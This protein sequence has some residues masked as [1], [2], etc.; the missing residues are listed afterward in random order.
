MNRVHLFN[1]DNDLALANFTPSFTPP[2]YA[3]EMVRGGEVLPY[4]LAADGDVVIASQE[5]AGWFDLMNRLTGKSVNLYCEESHRGFIPSPWGWSPSACRRFL[6]AGVEQHHIP[7]D[8]AIDDIRQL[9]HRRTSVTINRLLRQRGVDTPA[10]PVEV[11]SMDEFIDQFSVDDKIMLKSPWSS[12]GRGVIDSTTMPWRQFMRHV[13]GIIGRQG[14]VLIEPRLERRCDF[15]MLFVQS[16]GSARYEGLSL[17]KCDKHDAYVGNLVA[18]QSFIR[19]QIQRFGIEDHLLDI[20][21]FNLVE[22]LSCVVGKT[23]QGR[24]GVDMMVYTDVNGVNRIAPCVELNLRS[25]MGH[26][27]LEIE[28]QLLAPGSVGQLT[29]NPISAGVNRNDLGSDFMCGK[30]ASGN[31]SLVPRNSSF[32]FELVAKPAQL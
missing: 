23:Y 17:F 25:T 13:A 10:L 3:A 5:T 30:L 1:P 21:E 18:S 12:S 16:E 28:R 14:S 15:A 7:S 6:Q 19:E 22:L 11:R 24:M 2:R 29:M 32:M 20:I 9:S 8:E 31:F 4:W 27:A 26:L